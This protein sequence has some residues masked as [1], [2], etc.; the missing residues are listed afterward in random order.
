MKTSHFDRAALPP[1]RIFYEKELGRL[2]RPSRGWARGSCPFHESKSHKS[3]SVN[4]DDGG[5]YCFGCEAKGGDVVDF[6]RLRYR[7]DFKGACVELGA[8]H[9]EGLT[10]GDRQG[11]VRAQEIA[12]KDAQRRERIDARDHLH[13]VE[14]LYSE[15]IAEHDWYLMSELLPRVRQAEERYCEVAGLEVFA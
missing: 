2:S 12:Q 10:N 8:W 15:A 5:F 4:L 11:S 3:F 6:V 7:L 9:A 1:A 14:G 13:A